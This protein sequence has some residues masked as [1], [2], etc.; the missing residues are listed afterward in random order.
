MSTKRLGILGGLGTSSGVNLVQRLVRRYQSEGATKD[1]DFP[2]FVYHNLPAYGMDQFGIC[3]QE[4]VFGQLEDSMQ[5]LSDAKCS[6]VFI[7][8]MTVHIF[9]DRLQALFPSIVIVNSIAEACH[10]VQDCAKV[11]VLSSRNAKTMGLFGKALAHLNIQCVET[12][13]MLQKLLDEGIAKAISGKQTAQDTVVMVNIL[14]CIF[15]RGAQKVILGCTELPLLIDA[16]NDEQIVDA[17][18]CG[19]NKAIELIKAT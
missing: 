9:L 19:L 15:G 5:L 12:D 17:G 4:Q 11:G 13:E 8:C 6:V 14:N 7:A 16:S 3:N 1:S 18:L 10:K 2:D